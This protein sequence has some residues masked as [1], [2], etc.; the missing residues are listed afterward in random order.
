MD[1]TR[2]VPYTVG[3]S[4]INSGNIRGNN[5]SG[6]ILG[7]NNSNINC[8]KN[9]DNNH[10]NPQEDK[11]SRSDNLQD[12]VQRV[13]G[14]LWGNVLGVVVGNHSKDTNNIEGNYNKDNILGSNNS[15]LN[16]NN[17]KNN[18]NDNNTQEGKGSKSDKPA[19]L[20]A[21]KADSSSEKIEAMSR[22]KCE[23]L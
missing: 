5:N 13:P 9:D 12:N 20:E 11:G 17:N 3:D 2:F 19:M 8:N 14:N 22:Y 10:N 18:N 15:N 21:I 4:S 6:N 16:C 7:S 23:I 1:K